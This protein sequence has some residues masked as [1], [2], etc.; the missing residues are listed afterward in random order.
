[1]SCSR[2]PLP[3]YATHDEAAA[4][5]CARVFR[6]ASGFYDFCRRPQPGALR[7]RRH[8]QVRRR[9]VYGCAYV[10]RSVVDDPQARSV[11]ESLGNG[12]EHRFPCDRRIHGLGCA[13]SVAILALR[14]AVDYPRHC[15]TLPVLTGRP[16]SAPAV[17]SSP[18]RVNTASAEAAGVDSDTLK[19][20]VHAGCS[21]GTHNSGIPYR[22]RG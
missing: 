5:T 10:C 14:M 13:C 6:L 17:D 19:T 9:A 11:P 18:G 15:R 22:S 4:E 2:G 12:G 7:V 16:Q 8:R 3:R 1:V 20:N 21:S